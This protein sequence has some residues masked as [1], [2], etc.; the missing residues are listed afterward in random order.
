MNGKIPF[1][2]LSGGRGTRMGALAERY[3][4]KSLIPI[5]GSPALE[6][7]LRALTFAFRERAR[8]ILCIE[9][10]E[11]LPAMQELRANA[12]DMNVEIY[13][14]PSLKGTMHALYLLRDTLLQEEQVFVLYG[15]QPIHPQHLIRMN[16]E[17]ERAIVSLYP[18]SSN[19]SRK[20]SVVNREGEIIEFLQGGS[21]KGLTTNEY[22]LDVPYLLPV[23][24][25]RIMQDEY[26]RSHDAVEQWLQAG[27]PVHGH[28]ANFPH[29]FHYPHEIESVR[30][31]TETLRSD[32][33]A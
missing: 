23:N 25:V 33:T 20:I 3:R 24:F 16:E 21:E 14:N 22:Y 5:G 17:R 26:V 27:N 12:G 8:V 28:V 29:E 6:W 15:H 2:I 31:F 9:R 4:C 18:T 10:T 30:E 7:V 19:V 13:F 1:V 32:L 11:L